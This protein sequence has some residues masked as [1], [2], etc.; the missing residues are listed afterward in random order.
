MT[1][2]KQGPCYCH[3]WIAQ[4]LDG[5][6]ATLDFSFSFLQAFEGVD[7]GYESFLKG[8][9]VLVVGRTTYD[10]IVALESRWP[11]EG[12]TTYVVTH[13]EFVPAADGPTVVPWMQGIQALIALLDAGAETQ[14]HVWVIGG[15]AILK[16]F[17]EHDRID[18]H[19]LFV[20]PVLLG[21]GIPLFP[22]PGPTP[23]LTFT[24]S[25]TFSNGV[26]ELTYRRKTAQD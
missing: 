4:S 1:S 10:Q 21:A 24:S 12:R 16:Q 18:Q 26:V 13:R 11:Y 25:R 19:S 2:E 14:R 6:V 17:A 9:D 22:S 5:Y 23:G 7:Y 15:P 3:N 8:I 20:M